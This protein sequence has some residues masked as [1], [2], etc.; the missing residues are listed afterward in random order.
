MIETIPAILTALSPMIV[1]IAAAAAVMWQASHN[2]TAQSNKT[3]A[4]SRKTD[5]IHT[6][7]NS[8]LA[9]VTSALQVANEKISGLEKLVASM[10]ERGSKAPEV[11][12]GKE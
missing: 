6:L 5:E 12:G 2:A 1:A 10:V 7:T 4:L 8:N 9:S 11:V 3:E